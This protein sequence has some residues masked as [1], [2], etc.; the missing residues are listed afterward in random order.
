M[1][2]GAWATKKGVDLNSAGQSDLNLSS[3]RA[4]MKV[5]GEY[6]G[7]GTTGIDY[8]DRAE[9]DT[10]WIP[11]F[12]NSGGDWYLGCLTDSE[13]GLDNAGVAVGWIDAQTFTMI[14]NNESNNWR[15]LLCIDSYNDGT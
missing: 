11:F 8:E 5:I 1:G 3:D 6:D 2:I 15:Y 14:P 9:S 7:V 13:D 4:V 12:Q 10:I